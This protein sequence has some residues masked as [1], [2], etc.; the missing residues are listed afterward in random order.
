MKNLDKFLNKTELEL[1]QG[2]SEN[3][4]LMRVVKKVLLARVY[5]NGTLQKGKDPEPYKNFALS[6]VNEDNPMKPQ[7]VTN[8]EI[9]VRLRAAWEGILIIEEAFKEIEKYKKVA[10]EDPKENP[11][12]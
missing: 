12:I 7:K 8:E 3:E 5:E 10:E 4:S 6:Y 2:F 9:G 1:L 11:A